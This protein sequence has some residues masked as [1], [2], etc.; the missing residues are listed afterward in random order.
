MNSKVPLPFIFYQTSTVDGTRNS[1]SGTRLG[2]VDCDRREKRVEE[3]D[4]KKRG[5]T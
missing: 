2:R 4:K 5:K 1:G 3:R